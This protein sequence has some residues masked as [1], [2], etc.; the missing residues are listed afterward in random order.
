LAAKSILINQ[1]LRWT[2]S[3]RKQLKAKYST[4]ADFREH[5]EIPQDLINAII[6][7]GE[8]QKVVPKDDA[9]LQQTLPYLRR[10]LKA[11]IARDLWTINEYF[12]IINEQSD[13]VQRALQIIKE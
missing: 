1:N 12:D 2:D 7:E 10:Q 3:H 4:F 11:L 5:F 9:E 13:I 6:K 8:K